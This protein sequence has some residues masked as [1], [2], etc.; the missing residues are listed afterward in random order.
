VTLT[1]VVPRAYNAFDLRGQRRAT[2]VYSEA[3]I[4]RAL[5][6]AA[7]KNEAVSLELSADITVT[8]TITV[9]ATLPSFEL[10][11]SGRW[12]IRTSGTV[13]A[14]LDTYA[15][16]VILSGVS[17]VVGA[18]SSCSTLVFARGESVVAENVNVTTEAGGALPYVF[19]CG[20]A[21]TLYITNLDVDLTLKS[22]TTSLVKKSGGDWLARCVISTARLTA[23]TSIFDDAYDSGGF[24]FLAVWV[25][26]RVS[27]LVL[28]SATNLIA[29]TL[30]STPA[31]GSF[32]DCLFER[33][34][35]GISVAIGAVSDRNIFF[36]L[37]GNSTTTFATASSLTRGQTLRH[38]TGFTTRATGGADVD[39][40]S[41]FS[42]TLKG[43]VPASGG[44]TTNFLRADGTWA[45]PAGGGGGISDGDKGDVTVSGGGVTW[46]I[47]P[48]VVTNAKLANVST[49]TFKGRTT[50]GA[51]A[52]EDLTTAQAAALLGLPMTDVQA[53]TSAGVATWTKP[54][55]FTPKFVRVIAY[56]GGGGGGGGGSQTGAV[57]RCGGGG[58]GGGA[59]VE[60]LFRASDLA[61]TESIT[62]G[63][64]GTSGSGGL[65]T[66]TVGAAGGIGGTTSFSAGTTLVQAFGGGGGSGGAISAAAGGGGGGGGIGAAGTSGSASA[67]VGGGP[68][69]PAT[70]SGGC[71][72]S[73]SVTATAP[74]GAEYGGGGG[75]GHTAVPANSVGGGSMLGGGGGGCGAGATVTPALVAATAGGAAALAGGTGG[76]IGTAGAVG[77]VHRGGGGGGGGNGTITSGVQGS[78]GGAG[79]FPAG[80]GGGGGVGGAGT[81]GN[82]GAGG[83]GGVG[84]V[85]VLAW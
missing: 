61:A 42:S 3:D 36:Q 49:A 73:G 51:G 32:K 74:A 23:V 50:A 44:G 22:G 65:G 15:S 47:D 54:T 70:P 20:G 29:D 24:N 81:T 56:G 53:F 46:T 78:A 17:F 31:G 4:Q 35:G 34:R 41:T 10:N 60:R 82:G 63:A 84:A 62:V 66:G 39:L 2:L 11:G 67:G 8:K 30:G 83:V 25:N 40:D 79:G 59:R 18:G 19:K 28:N 21:G 77:G 55:A 68:G 69:A 71:G 13:D 37:T 6:L 33:F 76:A 58:G 64:A 7:Q 1:P 80:G 45:A 48:A 9:P 72:S 85:Y 5:T 14:L 57:V 27:D 43:I 26:C 38:V 12:K 16:L 75:G 52:P